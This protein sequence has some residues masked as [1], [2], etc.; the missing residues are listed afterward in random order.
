MEK[1]GT[2]YR[3]G[4]GEEGPCGVSLATGGISVNALF[5]YTES[6]PRKSPGMQSERLRK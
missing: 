1:G 3:A 6:G 2:D 5:K 4:E